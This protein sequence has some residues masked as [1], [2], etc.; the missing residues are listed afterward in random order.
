MFA[1]PVLQDQDARSDEHGAAN[2]REEEI[3]SLVDRRA[4]HVASK[5]GDQDDCET[6]KGAVDEHHSVVIDILA[7][8]IVKAHACQSHDQFQELDDG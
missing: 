7:R 5:Q 1:V 4:H 2:Q 3:K 6:N 8:V